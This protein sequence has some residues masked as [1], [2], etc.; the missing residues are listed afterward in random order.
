MGIKKRVVREMVEEHHLTSSGD[1]VFSYLGVQAVTQL[2][3]TAG[4]LVKV[5]RLTPSATLHHIHRH[6]RSLLFLA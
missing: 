3:D 1:Q 5:D 6:G 4:D 2:L